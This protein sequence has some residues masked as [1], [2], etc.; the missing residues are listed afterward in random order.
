MHLHALYVGH[1]AGN[2]GDPAMFAALESLLP[3]DWLLTCEAH[4]LRP[5][6][7]A[8]TRLIDHRD[9]A[10]C[11]AALHEADAALLP[12]T[13]IVTDL[14]GGEWPIV[15]ILERC[16]RAHELAKPVHAVGVG[17][18]SGQAWQRRRIAAELIP[19]C[20]TFSVRDAASR[21]LLLQLGAAEERV[22]LAA[23][24]SFLLP[25]VQG[26]PRSGPPVIGVNVVYEDWRG[27]DDFYHGIAAELDEF[28]REIKAHTRFVC[29]EVRD[30]EFFDLPAAR[31]VA[32]LMRSETSIAPADWRPPL[33]AVAQLTGCDLAVSVRYHFSIFAALAGVPWIGFERGGKLR[34][35]ATDFAAPLCGPMGEAPQGR[36]LKTLREAWQA[37]E[38]IAAR[39]QAAL[40]E[41][42]D[43]AAGCGTLLHAGLARK[44]RTGAAAFGL[45]QAR[46]AECH[47]PP[48]LRA[49][50]EE[51]L[52]NAEGPHAALGLPAVRWAL[53]P[54]TRLSFKSAGGAATLVLDA[55]R[56]D[57][58]HQYMDVRL[59]GEQVCRHTFGAGHDFQELRLPVRTRAGENELLIEYQSWGSRGD[60]RPLAVLYR[61]LQLLYAC[62]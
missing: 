4:E 60:A 55:R 57:D 9:R 54:R 12:G 37:R 51:G 19:L 27:C 49:D 41:L 5:W 18:Y 59:N 42:R 39:Q 24:L 17:L 50:V 43:R 23:D 2:L 53:G 11:D 33:E 34:A 13:T 7:R 38:A 48:F 28:A 16:W 35:L 21:D 62:Q 8:K 29:N 40:S 56:N 52:A 3:E 58:P 6:P 32:G 22:A 14:H 15:S 25:N 46:T 20:E 1:F 36:L 10:M 45:Q 44:R 31:R 30:E 26:A 61:R 47:A